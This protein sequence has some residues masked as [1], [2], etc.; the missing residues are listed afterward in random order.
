M[1]FN[2]EAQRRRDAETTQALPADVPQEEMGAAVQVTPDTGSAWWE[3]ILGWPGAL[4]G[5]LIRLTFNTRRRVFRRR[6]PDYVVFTLDGTLQERDPAI[7]WYYSFLPI[8]EPPLSIEYL[9]DALRR[10]AGDP[11]V[12][13][14]VFL[15]KEAGFSLAQAQSLAALLARFRRWDKEL[16]GSRQGTPKQVIFHLEEMTGPA[17]VAACAAD[18]IFAPPLADRA[19]KGIYAAPAFFK[20]SLAH[21]GIEF[22]VVRVAPW[23][24]AADTVASAGL[25]AAARDQY[26]WL[27]DSLFTMLVDAISSG[28]TLTPAAV[29]ALID[30]A[31]LAAPAAQAAGLIDGVAYEDELPRLLAV[32]GKDARLKP[33]QRIRGL[34]Y[35]RPKPANVLQI[36]VI[37]LTG[38]I[39]AGESRSFPMPIPLLGEATIGSATAQQMIRQARQDDGLSAVI[40]HVDS[41]GGSAL[42][43]DLIWRELA[44]LDQTKPVIVY[45]GDVAAS[46]GYYI[47]APGRKIVA[48]GATLTG[49]IGVIT[50]KAVT[51]GAY[52]L[53]S[54]RREELQRGAHAGLESDLRPWDADERRAVEQS[55]AQIYATFKQRVV[56]GRGIDPV[57]LEE[58]AGGRVWTGA[59]A[60]ANGLVDQLGDFQTAVELACVAAGYYCRYDRTADAHRSAQAHLDG[61]AV[62]GSRLGIGIQARPATG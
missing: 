15:V 62:G 51:A 1:D 43:S 52:D 6:L 26:N 28:R 60:A 4:W 10:V 59:Q 36:G 16:A 47:A 37:S 57:A 25:S 11:A 46:G 2:A 50:A 13:G 48:Q 18:R 31:P 21:L 8:Y 3:T 35:R 56:D 33:Y 53:I 42:A 20:E 32:N 12:R 41:P 14:V 9:D 30:Q 7:P 38:A 55:V 34:L 19:V 24:T 22:D 40:V 45:M 17:Y 58:L 49:S 44:L 39:M 61:S 5:W 29:G 54:A 23:K 27:F